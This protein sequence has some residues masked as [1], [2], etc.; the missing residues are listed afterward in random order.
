MEEGKLIL[1]LKFLSL[2]RKKKNVTFRFRKL[3]PLVEDKFFAD[4]QTTNSRSVVHAGQSF[5]FGTKLTNGG[6]HVRR[7]W[8][9]EKRMTKVREE[10]GWESLAVWVQIVSS[11]LRIW[12]WHT[13]TTER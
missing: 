8:S 2:A 4:S 9:L 10:E 3:F 1:S 5:C 11:L 6:C 12:L 7:Y 13:S